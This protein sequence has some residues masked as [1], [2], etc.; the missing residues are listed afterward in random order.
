MPS[1]AALHR[2]LLGLDDTSSRLSTPL[3]KET[4]RS[5]RVS[6]TTRNINGRGSWGG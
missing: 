1:A 4:F 3:R 6:G 5:S 2:S